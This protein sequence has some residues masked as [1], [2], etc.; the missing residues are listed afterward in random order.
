LAL[1]VDATEILAR[2]VDERDQ[3]RF[4]LGS[5][6][7]VDDA[8]P[9]VL[10]TNGGVHSTF[11]ISE[12]PH[13][14]VPLGFLQDLICGRQYRS[15]VTPVCTTEDTGTGFR[16][17][18]REVDWMASVFDMNRRLGRR[19]SILDRRA[20]P[21]LKERENELAD[22]HVQ[23]RVVGYV[24]VSGRDGDELAGHEDRMHAAAPNLDLQR[25]K[26]LQWEGIVARSRPV[27][28]GL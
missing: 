22:G 5:A 12:W 21:D 26:H 15:V 28:W 8:D 1:D 20:V 25:L 14:E 6:L 23:L 13:T 27:G 19:T 10:V 4:D 7:L 16:K 2:T 18:S 3:D 17:T 24:R 9:E 11:W